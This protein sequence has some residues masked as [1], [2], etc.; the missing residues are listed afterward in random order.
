MKFLFI[1]ET[2]PDADHPTTGTYNLALCRE[3][4]RDHEVRVI[5]PRSWVDVLRGKR[6]RVPAGLERSGIEVRYPTR[7]YTPNFAQKHYGGQM[8]WSIGGALRELTH[9][10]TPD[11]VLSY[12]AHPDGECG[13]RASRKFNAPCAVIVG[14]T[15]VLILP[16]MPGR[17]PCVRRVLTDSDA[18]ITVSDG[19]KTACDALGAASGRVLT[20][21][22]GIDPDVFHVGDQA[23]ARRRLGIS[24]TPA[25]TLTPSPSPEGRGGPEALL[26]WVGRMVG[27]KRVDLLIQATRM[28]KEQGRRVRVC[29]LGSGPCR[30]QWQQLAQSE[31]VADQIQFVGPVSHDQL[32]DWYRAADLTVLCSESEGLPNVL[33]ESVA[34]GTPFVSTDVGSIREIADPDYSELVPKHDA[35]ALARGIETVLSGPHRAAAQ[36]YQPRTWSETARDTVSLF[37]ELI[38]HRRSSQSS[39]FSSQS[40]VS[41]G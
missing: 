39:V 34:C 24:G 3:L 16:N 21:R 22:Q 10:W 12:W 32:A 4:A 28:L 8:W 18:V 25:S 17:G 6:F 13:L 26:V 1:S 23:E 30:D 20:I 19:L 7:W 40:R 11:A 35:A 36:S 33:R 31:C 14:G 2:F 5:S 41:A 9:D 15:D 37:E 29:L 38:A 27:L